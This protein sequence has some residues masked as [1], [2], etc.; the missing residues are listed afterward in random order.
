MG[1]KM[2]CDLLSPMIVSLEFSGICNSGIASLEVSFCAEREDAQ[3]R[4]RSKMSDLFM[5]KIS[6]FGLF[7]FG[8]EIATECEVEVDPV[9]DSTIAEIDE[10]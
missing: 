1:E 4:E 8:S 7:W 2:P 5:M 9:L 3:L 10:S 6:L